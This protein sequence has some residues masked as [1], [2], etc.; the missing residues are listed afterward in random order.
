MGPSNLS[1]RAPVASWQL[2]FETGRPAGRSPDAVSQHLDCPEAARY[3][4]QMEI[5]GFQP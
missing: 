5:F 3:G 1:C 4:R 2:R